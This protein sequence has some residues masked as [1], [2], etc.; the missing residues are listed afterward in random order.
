MAK[1]QKQ[2]ILVR[3]GEIALKSAPVRREYEKRLKENIK[4]GLKGHGI[5]NAVVERQRGRI[6]IH[7]NKSKMPRALK[8]LEKTFGVVSFSPAWHL[9][10]DE[11]KKIQ[12]FVK[13][14]YRSWVGRGKN[15]AVRA[16]R[17]GTQRER[18]TS[19][20]LAKLVGDVVNRRVDLSE[21]DVE[22]FVE[23]RGNDTYIYT[24]VIPGPGGL[25]VGTSGGVVCLLSGGIDSAVAAWLMMKRGCRVV[26]LYADN[27]V[28]AEDRKGSMER[29]KRVLGVLQGWS[30]GWKIPFYSFDNGKS[31]ERFLKSKDVP[32]KFTCLLCKRMM[33][34]VANEVAKEWKAKAIVTG[35]SLGEVASQTLDNLAVL[36]DASRLPVFRPL[37]GNDKQQTIDMAREIGTYE[38]SV[39]VSEG[40]EAVPK[41]PRT[42]GKTAEIERIESKLNM[43]KLLR[44]S[45]K[46]IKK[47]ESSPKKKMQNLK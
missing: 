1:R 26:A 21:P 2:V 39:S 27:G 35:E 34:R 46:S 33:Y 24:K 28:Y 17:V 14:N 16:R 5:K 31:L 3:Y 6:F 25:P 19:M 43:K 38:I 40:C 20:Q 10:T 44:E 11:V 15:F 7:V 41:A 36:E 42:M 47:I 4:A 22:I 32:K 45:M 18:Y 12:K 9:Q 8:T 30:N 13:D 37:L 29:V 23:V